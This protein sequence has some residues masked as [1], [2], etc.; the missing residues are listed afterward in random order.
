MSKNLELEKFVISEF[1][2]LFKKDYLASGYPWT[3]LFPDKNLSFFLTHSQG[4]ARDG[5]RQSRDPDH[6]D[7]WDGTGIPTLSR[8][9]RPCLLIAISEIN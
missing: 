7:L 5:T 2:T 8:D 3:R 9:N 6:E 4:W 1:L